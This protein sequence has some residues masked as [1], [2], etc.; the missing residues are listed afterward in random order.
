M[1][2]NDRPTIEQQRNWRPDLERA[3]GPCDRLHLTLQVVVS[4]Q[5]KDL[6]K[7]HPDA[8]GNDDAFD[9]ASSRLRSRLYG[10]VDDFVDDYWYELRSQALGGWAVSV[11]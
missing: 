1:M 8:L 10:I 11:R 2:Q 7:S 5:F 9:D 3:D 6:A 4:H